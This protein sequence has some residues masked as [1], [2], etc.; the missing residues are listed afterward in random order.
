MKREKIK[1]IAPKLAALKTSKE[2]FKMPV[3]ALEHTEV[4][5]L[6]QLKTIQLKNQIKSRN[7]FKVEPN[8]F[9]NFDDQIAITIKEQ[10]LNQKKS[11]YTI[12]ENYFNTVESKVLNKLHEL[13]KEKTVKVISL[14]TK[15]FRYAVAV[16]IA[17]SIALFFIL[18]PLQSTDEINFDSLAL[19]EI[20]NWIEQDR[21]DLDAYQIA[22]VYKDVQLE[23]NLL[24]NIEN[25]EEM[26]NFLSHENIDV[27]MY[28][29]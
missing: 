10:N 18:N 7:P 14:Y 20:E 16:A 24:K 26:E 17:A 21:L 25:E 28:N 2:V 12:P 13:P 6:A 22:A 29:E 9:E 1:H 27:L 23:P 11:T 19:S 4:S 5:V 3:G 8:Y 15:V